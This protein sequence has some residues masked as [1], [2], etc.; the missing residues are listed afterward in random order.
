[1]HDR[2]AGD[3]IPMTHAELSNL[4]SI[5]RT[6]VTLIVG[7]LES[8]GIIANRRGAVEVS[9]RFALESAACECYGAMRRLHDAFDRRFADEPVD[10]LPTA[11]APLTDLSG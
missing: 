5:R 3:V 8:A 11:V 10:E 4:A 6:T 2:T 7:S 9:D 1:M